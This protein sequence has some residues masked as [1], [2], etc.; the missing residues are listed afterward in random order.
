MARTEDAF[1]RAAAR[2][3]EAAHGVIDER[4]AEADD[5]PPRWR[6]RLTPRLAATAL[7]AIALIAALVVWM[8]RGDTV[9]LDPVEAVAGLGATSDGGVGQGIGATPSGPQLTA[10]TVHVAGAVTQPGVYELPAGARVEDAVAAAGGAL[11]EARLDA[12]NLARVVNDGEQILVPTAAEAQA[13]SS[14]LVNVNQADAGALEELP[15]VGPVLA[16]RIVSYREA[17]GS[18]A[19]VDSL[20]AVPGIGPAVLE[21]L[22]DHATV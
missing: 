21:G 10:T 6:W 2:A 1:R 3:Y 17:H 16:E 9:T 12:L 22:R 13:V 4:Q 11:A 5:E 8:P 18:F 19:T 14:G 15:G 7:G 20:E